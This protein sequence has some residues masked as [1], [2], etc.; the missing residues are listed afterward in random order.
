MEVHPNGVTSAS[1]EVQ[2]EP[3]GAQLKKRKCLFLL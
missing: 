3:N 2:L 1:E